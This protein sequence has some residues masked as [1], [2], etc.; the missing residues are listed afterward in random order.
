[1]NFVACSGNW[2]ATTDGTLVCQG[3]LATYT[4]DQLA[5]LAGALSWDDVHQ[6]SGDVL[7]L[8]CSVFGF[9]VLRKALNL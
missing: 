8:F 9:L 6:L 5:T 2:T 4:G 1:M 7:T 3:E